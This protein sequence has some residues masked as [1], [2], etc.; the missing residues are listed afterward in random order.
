MPRYVLGLLAV[1]W[2]KG[3][4]SG[5]KK[6]SAN[7]LLLETSLLLLPAGEPVAG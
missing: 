1:V 6:P 5:L 2:W 3:V 4:M 7:L